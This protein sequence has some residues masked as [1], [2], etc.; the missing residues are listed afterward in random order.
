MNKQHDRRV[1]RSKQLLEDA[2]A[3]LM[4][5]KRFD[6]ITIQD[7]LDRANVGRTTFYAHFQSKEALFLS[8][9]AGMVDALACAFFT[10][11]GGLRSEPS[12]ELISTLETAQ[13]SGDAR[14]YLTWGD[15][16]GRILQLL[17]ERLAEKITEQLRADY[18]ANESEIP[19]DVLAQQVATSMLHLLNWWMDKRMRYP[20]KEMAEMLYR[21]NM[22]VLRDALHL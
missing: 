8:T 15:E 1:Q 20:A 22:I 17:T 14:F 7:I 19:F 13:Q 6:K 9:H 4:A 5:E 10:A 12:P 18:T 2:L 3:E 21:M 16:T 11:E